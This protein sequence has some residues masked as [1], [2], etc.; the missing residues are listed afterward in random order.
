MTLRSDIQTGLR[1]VVTALGETWQYRRLT[2]GPGA[3]T[4]TYGTW[5]NVTAHATGRSAPQEWDDRRNVWK[6]VER[7]RVR[8][9]D[10]LTDLHQG[11]EIQDPS[12]AVFSVQGIASNAPNLGS[13]AYDCARSVPLKVEG[14]NRDGGV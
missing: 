9:S 11:D 14:G 3:S 8:V 2:S 13:I 4:R 12:G 7:V 10:V 5:T 1:D 6:R